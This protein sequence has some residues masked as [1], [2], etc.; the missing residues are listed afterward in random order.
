M[1]AFP[2]LFNKKQTATALLLG[3][4][5]YAHLFYL[6]QLSQVFIAFVIYIY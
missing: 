3:G 5:T 4:Q 2:T 1:F 6:D